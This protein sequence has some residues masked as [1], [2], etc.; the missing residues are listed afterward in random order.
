MDTVSFWVCEKVLD[1]E[2]GDGCIICVAKNI[3]LC[4][5]NGECYGMS[6]IFQ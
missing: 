3:Q 4:A 1:L 5:L 2:R 6:I